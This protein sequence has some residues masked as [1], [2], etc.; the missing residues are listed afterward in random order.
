MPIVLPSATA[1]HKILVTGANG[2]VAMWVIQALLDEGFSVRGTVRS[3]EKGEWMG[4]KFEEFGEKFEWVVVGDITKDGAFDEAVK[5]VV[6]VQ[7]MASPLIT[8][9]DDPDLFIQPAVHGTLGILKSAQK[10]GTEIRRI[11][12]ISSCGAIMQQVTPGDTTGPRIL[13]ENDWG[14]IWVDLVKEKGKD[15]PQ[16]FKYRA[17]KVLAEQGAWKWYEENKDVVGWDLVTLNPPYILGPAFQDVSKPSDLPSSLNA[18]YHYMFTE[19][20]E[21]LLTSSHC[22]VHVKD[23]ARAHVLALETEEAAN[24]RIII[25]S[26]PATWQQNRDIVASIRPTLV[27]EE[28]LPVGNSSSK[29]TIGLVYNP[30]KSKRIFDL[31]YIGL[32]SM[33]KDTV[34]F[35]EEKG[36]IGKK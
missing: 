7:H 10:A 4:K 14:N 35:L 3:K 2:F 34:E 8:D 25:S 12:I 33:I 11:V 19:Q 21:S 18:W 15:V 30:A 24:Q 6:G 27:D 31:Q 1:A 9:G 32:E 16:I 22:F 28:V 23:V 20:P 29:G 17:A 36:I 26:E 13:D 5:G